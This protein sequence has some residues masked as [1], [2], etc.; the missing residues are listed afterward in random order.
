LEIKR[1]VLAGELSSF[2]QAALPIAAA[3]GGMIVPALLY[4]TLNAGGPGAAGWGVPMATDIAFALGV[5]ALLG[6]R[7]PAALKVFLAAFAI[8]DD[9]GAVLVIALFYTATI[10]F[11]A[12]V[13]GFGFLVLAALANWSGSVT[14]SCTCSL[15]GDLGGF[16]GVGR[17]C[18]GSRG[19]ARHDHPRKRTA[20]PGPV[21][22][23]K[24]KRARPVRASGPS[25]QH[26]HERGAAS[27][28]SHP[29]KRRRA[30]A[31]A[32]AAHGTRAP[33]LGIVFHHARL[34]TGQRRGVVGRRQRPAGIASPVPLGII[35]GLVLGKPLGVTLFAWLAVRSGLAAKPQGVTWAHL[36]GAGWLGG[37]GFTMAL[38]IAGLAFAEPAA[39]AAAKQGILCASLIAGV[40]G[41]VLL[42][43]SGMRDEIS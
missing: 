26:P 6:N 31:D 14:R 23:P 13:V 17:A 3:L 4:T 39:L 15:A 36:H 16:L 2:R 1:E 21:P 25:Q 24:Q 32:A 38:F 29:G 8:A 10:H 20:R 35:A 22:G 28:A 18:H 19:P 37:I 42:R 27:G 12:L 40:V 5:L 34:R 33:P 11:V 43:R 30:G 7:V 41:F 9:I